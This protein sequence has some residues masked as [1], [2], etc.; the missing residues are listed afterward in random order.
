[1]E[2]EASLKRALRQ[3]DEHNTLWKGAMIGMQVTAVLQNIYVSQ[4]QL[5]LQS[6]EEKGTKK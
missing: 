2:L 1:T 4:S 3:S 5:Q 6:V